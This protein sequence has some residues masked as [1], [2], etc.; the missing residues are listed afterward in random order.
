M[1]RDLWPSYEGMSGLLYH[2]VQQEA[3]NAE[4]HF[5]VAIQVQLKL[6]TVSTISLSDLS[7]AL[8]LGFCVYHPWLG[9]SVMHA[10]NN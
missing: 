6:L 8:C 5:T 1:W 4:D 10:L 9:T 2:H 7:F 3:D